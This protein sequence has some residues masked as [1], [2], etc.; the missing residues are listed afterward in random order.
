MQMKINYRQMSILVFMSF[1][2]LKM[3][4]LPSV[5]YQD[6]GNMSWL[7]TLVLMTID[8]LYAFLI[9]DMMK[10]CGDKNIF[11]FMRACVGGFLARVIMVVYI[12]KFALVIANIS[13]GLEFFVVEN[14]YSE[15]NWL[16]FVLPLIILL[17]F[18][19]YKGIRNIARVNELICWAVVVG[20]IYIALKSIG[21]VDFLSFLPMFKEGAKPI[22]TGAFRHLSW[23]GSA[24]FLMML[25]GS[26]DF[27]SEKKRTLVKYCLFGIGL[28]IL[29]H[30]V[31]YGLFDNISPMRN[32][33]LSDISQYSSEHNSIDELS[34]LI[35]AL[36]VVA[37]GVQL[38]L[39]GYCLLQAIKFMFN[40]Q[41]NTFPILAIMVYVLLWSYIGENTIGLERI[42]FKPISSV[43][44]ILSEYTIPPLLAII[45][46]I[47]NR[48]GRKKSKK[49]GAKHEKV[50]VNIQSA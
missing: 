3:L 23:F 2:S 15:F 47:K 12:L 7:V 17:G 21:S 20:C 42:F 33:A 40:I 43:V 25:F 49:G 50:A 45:F 44:T 22:F 8:M 48:K 29:V 4:G 32:F 36:W 34:W 35:V 18:M 24:S 9:V 46:A 31:F 6:S 5:I 28:V 13:K 39:Y 11:E 19:V 38:A 27:S 26:V 10:K 16:V 37:Q 30:V 1:I 14:F 41:N